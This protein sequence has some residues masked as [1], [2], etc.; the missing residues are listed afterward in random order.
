[1]CGRVLVHW[2]DWETYLLGSSAEDLPAAMHRHEATGRPLGS[3]WLVEKLQAFLGRTLLPQKRGPK[4]K[5][6]PNVRRD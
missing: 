1:M 5:G 4:P 2:P 6:K 3:R